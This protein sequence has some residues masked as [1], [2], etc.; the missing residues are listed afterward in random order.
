MTKKKVNGRA[1]GNRG[2]NQVAKLLAPW[3]G[4][5]F[6]STPLS[7]GFATKQF[8]DDWNAA[9]DV[10]T[11]DSDFPFCVEVKLQEGW[12]FAQIL[13]S[14]KCDPWKWWEQCV[15]E[16]PVRKIPLLV[17]RKNRQPWYYMMYVEDWAGWEDA[18]VRVPGR[19][20]CTPVPPGDPLT[21][22]I[23]Y[24]IIGLFEDFLQS[25]TDEWIEWYEHY[26]PKGR[27]LS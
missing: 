26:R 5:E 9:G 8:R 20:F 14:E 15:G 7:G 11:P 19:T 4:S 22:N 13:K 6:A 21:D 1:K 18:I 2:Q 17:F 12:D 23:R 27:K 24:V 3:W 25:D 10:V 16:T